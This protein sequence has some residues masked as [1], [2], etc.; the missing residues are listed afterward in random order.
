[1]TED[2]KLATGG[3]MPENLTDYETGGYEP[4]PSEDN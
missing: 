2:Y 1:M 3:L 4:E